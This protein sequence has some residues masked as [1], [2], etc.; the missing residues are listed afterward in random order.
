MD[1]SP[2]KT[3]PRGWTPED[4]KRRV[5]FVQRRSGID[6]TDTLVEAPDKLAGIIE[7]HIGYQTIPMAVAAPLVLDGEYAA[8]KFIVPVCTLEGTLVYSLTRGMM[9]TAESGIRIRHLWQRISRAPM[10]I[11]DDVDTITP[12]FNFVDKH[13]EGIR[14]AAEST[15][16]YG[17]LLEI[18]KIPIHKA[19]VLEL[20]FSTGNAAG[21]NMVTIAAQAA[22]QYIQKH[23]PIKNYY[24][25]SGLNCDKKAS[26]RTLSVGRGHAVAAQAHIS[27]KTLKL[28][29]GVETEHFIEFSRAAI[30][31]GQFAGVLGSQLHIANALAAVYLATGQDMGCVAE[32]SVGNIDFTDNKDGSVEVMLTLPSITV[33]TV[34]GG[35][36]LP[37]Q[38]R[39]LELLGC[40]EGEHS[41]KKLAEIIGGVA[42]CLEISLLSAIVSNTFA[43]AHAKFGRTNHEP[44][45]E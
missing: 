10:F 42:M 44:K 35:T 34:G 45:H 23:F 37:S 21:Q 38:R 30:A 20:W 22:C 1:E 6:F 17:K 12:F 39:N 9:A 36:R 40:A 27:S 3:P 19:V 15:T 29:L 16:R 31:A 7:Q 32:N 43:Q 2:L 14:A 33:G 26:R 18:R 13:F 24:L 25:E 4:T 41:A 11:L 28:L 8:G 5:D